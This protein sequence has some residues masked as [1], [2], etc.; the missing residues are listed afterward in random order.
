MILDT[1]I[2]TLFYSF[3]FGIYFSFIVYLTY[4]Y[5]YKL[6][7]YYKIIITFFFI[8][9]NTLIYFLILLKINNGIIHIYG[10]F[11]LLLGFL[12][13]HYLQNIIEKQIKK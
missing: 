5:I 10:I 12:I 13:E 11:S 6:K 9:F 4:K 8:F 7:K 1:Q 3:L 2:K